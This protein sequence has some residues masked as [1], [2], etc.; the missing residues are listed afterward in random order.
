MVDHPED[1]RTEVRPVRTAARRPAFR[2]L[3][4]D[5]GIAG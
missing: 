2:A 4:R 3:A 5:L 1:P